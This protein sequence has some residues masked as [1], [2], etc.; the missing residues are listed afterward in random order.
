MKDIKELLKV[1]TVKDGVAY[2]SV[3][4][5]QVTNELVE[6]PFCAEDLAMSVELCIRACIT[7][8]QDKIAKGM[9]TSVCGG[10]IFFEDYTSYNQS[11]MER[12]EKFRDALKDFGTKE[13]SVDELALT[14]EPEELEFLL[15]A[16]VE[17]QDCWTV[18]TSDLC[19]ALCVCVYS[20]K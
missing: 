19:R 6:E 9:V 1:I 4:A 16:Y 20:R 12:M 3:N 11:L 2:V 8:A 14:F 17:G 13:F 10:T 5:R 18:R 15:R 7:K